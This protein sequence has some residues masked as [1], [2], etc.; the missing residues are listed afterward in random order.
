MTRSGVT[1]WLTEKR[2]ACEALAEVLGVAKRNQGYI[3]TRNGD[4]VTHNIGHLLRQ[5]NPRDIDPRWGF[6]YEHLPINPADIPLEPEPD[7]R[8]QLQV[9]EDLFRRERIGRVVLAGEA[10]RGGSLIGR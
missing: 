4:V 1:V 3:V 7:K 9:I 2:S 10:G 5:K 6:A 8:Q